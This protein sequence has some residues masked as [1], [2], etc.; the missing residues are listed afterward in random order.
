VDKLVVTFLV[1]I[2][3]GWYYWRERKLLPIMVAHGLL[4]TWG[5]G[6]FVLG[7]F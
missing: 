4:D 3:T 1:G 6:I 5:Y 7:L 2:I